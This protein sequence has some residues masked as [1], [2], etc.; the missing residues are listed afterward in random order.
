M[1]ERRFVHVTFRGRVQ[2][3]GF[4]AFIEGEAVERA[5]DGWVRNREDGSVEAVFSGP[6]RCRRGDAGALPQGPARR[7]RRARSSCARRR[8]RGSSP[9]RVR[10]AS[11]SC[12]RCERGTL[13]LR[14]DLCERKSS[15]AS[16][17][18][19][20]L[21]LRGVFPGR[22]KAAL[23]AGFRERAV[24]GLR[25][26]L[27][28]FPGR[29]QRKRNETRDPSAGT[30]PRSGAELIAQRSPFGRGRHPFG[31]TFSTGP[32]ASCQAPKPPSI[33]ATGFR[34]IS[35]A[36]AAASAERMPPAQK[37]TKRLS[38]ANTGLW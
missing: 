4:R 37:K 32:P 9:R 29:M 22:P 23:A 34:P 16:S 21:P 2:G 1:T 18:P 3:I 13:L 20:S 24:E 12:R 27:H 35:F 28:R 10:P 5:L 26:S 25:Q 31:A 38:S 11:T 14:G 36:V 6:A 33:W 7:A 30:P 15:G 19:D 8:P 17:R